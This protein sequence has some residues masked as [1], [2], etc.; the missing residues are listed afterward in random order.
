MVLP[1]LFLLV[2]QLFLLCRVFL[3]QLLRLLLMLL[4]DQLFFSGIRLLLH[5]FGVFLFLLLLDSLAVLF[6][7]CAKLIL[8]LL[9]LA[10]QFGIGGGWNHGPWRSRGLVRMGC[11]RRTRASGLWL[12]GWSL[13]LRGVLL[14]FFGDCQLLRGLLLRLFCRGLLSHLPLRG[15]LLGSFRSGLLGSLLL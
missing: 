15:F 10:V 3:Q 11:R 6:L 5:E 8:L 13:A 12:L 2:R 1:L 14:G 9:V 7:L 4:F